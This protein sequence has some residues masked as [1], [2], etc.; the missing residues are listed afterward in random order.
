MENNQ[1]ERFYT[2]RKVRLSHL[3]EEIG[4]YLKEHG[5]A[6]VQSI[7][8]IGGADDHAKYSLELTDLNLF[9]AKPIGEIRIKSEAVHYTKE[10]WK[11]GKITVSKID[12]TFQG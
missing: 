1:E 3:Y 7:G 11:S 10:E 8:S 9:S 2:D 12:T 6:N 4:K 5:D